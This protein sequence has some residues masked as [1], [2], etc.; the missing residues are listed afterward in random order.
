MYKQ[1][2]SSL[3]QNLIVSPMTCY[4]V[5]TNMNNT[6]LLQLVT[7]NNNRITLSLPYNGSK[8]FS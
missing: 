4:I 1:N 5:K 2:V 3:I 8:P 7:I 6:V